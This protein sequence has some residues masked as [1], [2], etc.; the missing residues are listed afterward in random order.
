MGV[1]LTLNLVDPTMGMGVVGVV[2]RG[3]GTHLE[4]LLQLTGDT[5]LMKH[6]VT[7]EGVETRLG[8]E[9]KVGV[10]TRVGVEP[11]IQ[12]RSA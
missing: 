10:E 8:V 11:L 5:L 9:T 12:P 4:R 3:L 2:M 6:M 1:A 7:R